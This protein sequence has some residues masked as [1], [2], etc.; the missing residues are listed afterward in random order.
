MIVVIVPALAACDVAETLL[1]PQWRP[2]SQSPRIRWPLGRSRT[3]LIVAE[4]DIDRATH[5]FRH[6]GAI[7][8]TRTS[9]PAL[10]L[11][12]AEASA[13]RRPGKAS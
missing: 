6:E 5:Y 7:E 1:S 8:R 9:A 2:S 13:S 12:I 4:A 3:C 10:L 11:V